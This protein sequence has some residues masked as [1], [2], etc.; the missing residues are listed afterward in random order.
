MTTKVS[1]FLFVSA[2]NIWSAKRVM[3]VKV[4]AKGKERRERNPCHDPKGALYYTA[5]WIP[6]V[7]FS[8]SNGFEIEKQ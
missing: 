6:G 7:L 4:I 5:V 2:I 3:V 1:E 8:I